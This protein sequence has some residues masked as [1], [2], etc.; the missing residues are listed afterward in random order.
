MNPV[1]AGSWVDSVDREI[2]AGRLAVGW[3]HPHFTG[4][5]GVTLGWQAVLRANSGPLSGAVGLDAEQ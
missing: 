3:P 5:G 4:M 2:A 1:L